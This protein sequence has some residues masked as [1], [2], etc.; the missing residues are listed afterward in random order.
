MS[1]GALPFLVPKLQMREAITEFLNWYETQRTVNVSSQ[2]L[3]NRN[4]EDAI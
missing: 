3:R 4:A 2:K 1:Y